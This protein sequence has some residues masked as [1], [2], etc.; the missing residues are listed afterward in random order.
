MWKP[1]DVRKLFDSIWRGFPIGTLLWWKRDASEATVSF[2]PSAIDVPAVKDANWIVD[3]QQRVASLV[4]ALS[5]AITEPDPVFNV[6]FD[7]RAR[8]FVHVGRRVSPPWWLPLR[9]AL[10]TSI[11]R[12]WVR[13]NEGDLRDDELQLADEL[14]GALRDYKLPV[15]VVENED[16]DLLRDL[17]DRVNSA[18][19]PITRAEAFH[20][21]FSNE[22]EPGSPAAVATSL[23]RHGFGLIPENQIVQSLLGIRGGDIARDIHGE[24]SSEESPADWYDRTEQA[25]SRSIRFLRSQGVPHLELMPTK[26]PLPILATV[27]H[28]HPDIPGWYERLL[29]RWL[30]RGWAHGFSSAPSRGQT[31]V[32]RAGVRVVNP[33]R[34]RPDRAPDTFE[35]L[36]ALLRSVPDEKPPDVPL[37]PFR[38]NRG[39]S[40][41]V[42]LALV[43]LGPRDVEG[44]VVD[45]AAA[46]EERGGLNSVVT[47]LVP[48][49]RETGAARGF[50]PTDVAPPHGDEPGA[51]LR[52][53]AVGQ[54]A[55]DALQKGNIGEFLVA[56]EETL[57]DLVLRFL[58]RRLDPGAIIRPS[59]DDLIVPD[60]VV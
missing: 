59:L 52:S 50:W 34:N 5:S 23:R 57:Q 4:G 40:V 10:E 45:I 55:A 56:R 51:V 19:H 13:A 29:A 20:A 3:G 60:P 9:L 7:L 28:L 8:R 36:Q 33:E 1:D 58:T 21:L 44:T 24:F 6:C 18:G 30:W 53:H 49:H 11:Y 15:Y 54:D 14:G 42:L 27:F 38:T 41:L 17:F 35:A 26:L 46:I 22:A 37:T 25:L 48:G 32:L 43:S 12:T 31:P 47:E 39:D 16:D 2:G